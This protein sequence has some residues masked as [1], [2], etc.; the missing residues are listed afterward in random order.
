MCVAVPAHIVTIR[1]L[2]ADVNMG[3][4]QRGISL[5]LT[6]EARVGDYVYVHAG[7]AVSILDET[8]ALE[9]LQVLEGLLRTHSE[10]EL[11]RT[12]GD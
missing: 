7:F 10:D 8:E 12:A 4:A 5:W 9:N 6:P 2:E 11:F 1:G 3:G